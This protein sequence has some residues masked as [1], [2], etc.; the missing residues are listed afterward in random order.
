MTDILTPETLR[1]EADVEQVSGHFAQAST[2]DA[3]AD[4]WEA[5]RK[6]LEVL[7]DVR[8][9]ARDILALVPAVHMNDVMVTMTF[10]RRVATLAT[11]KKHKWPHI[12]DSPGE[13]D[14]DAYKGGT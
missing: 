13:P 1:L 11:E 7:E 12:D 10:L 6:R 4:A 5:D 3:H 8:K 2:I 9:E 14:L